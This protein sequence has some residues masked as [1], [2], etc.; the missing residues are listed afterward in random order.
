MAT[1]GKIQGPARAADRV[2]RIELPITVD[3]SPVVI[4]IGRW[5]VGRIIDQLLRAERSA[6]EIKRLRARA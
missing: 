6:D 3:G 1:V 2:G 5:E 4:H